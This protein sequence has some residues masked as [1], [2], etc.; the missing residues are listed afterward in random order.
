MFVKSSNNNLGIG[1]FIRM[2]ENKICEV[3]YFDLPHRQPIVEKIHAEL[4][5]VTQDLLLL[6]S[7]V[8]HHRPDG[9]WIIGKYI[10]RQNNIV[11]VK[12]G[13]RDDLYSLPIEQTYIRCNKP[14]DDPLFM[15]QHGIFETPRFYEGRLSFISEMMK[16]RAN[17]FG[18]TALLS[19]AINLVDHQ[20]NTTKKI[21]HDPIQ[22]YLLADEV[23][24]GKTI[25]AGVLI[26]QHVLDNHDF[27]PILILVPAQLKLQWIEEL[28]QRFF[29]DEFIQTKIFIIT[30]EELSIDD[31]DTEW[32][33]LVIDEAHHIANYATFPENSTER[34]IF[35]M[36]ENIA[37]KTE[38]L[39]LL[40]A[41]PALHNESAFLT[42][43]S[44]LDPVN[45][46]LGNLDAF[47]E[48]ITNMKTISLY[49]SGISL[50]SDNGSIY[51]SAKALIDVL[52]EDDIYLTEQLKQLMNNILNEDWNI[53]SRNSSILALNSYISEKFKVHHRIARTRRD[54]K[55][56]LTPGRGGLQVFQSENTDFKSVDDMFY[57][58]HQAILINFED[59]YAL[60]LFEIYFKY[61]LALS[62]KFTSIIKYRMGDVE[63]Q[64]SISLHEQE[65]LTRF[66][67]NNSESSILSQI[68]EIW[69]SNLDEIMV[70]LVSRL[71]DLCQ[72]SK[73]ILF[74]ENDDVD[75]IYQK[76]YEDRPID[77]WVL[78]HQADDIFGFDD[79]NKPDWYQFFSN[80][81]SKI[82]VCGQ[83]G[84]EGLNLQENDSVVFHFSIPLAVNRI[85][86]R[87]G[88]VDR[89]QRS[90]GKPV[91]SYII[92][93]VNSLY[94]SSWIN[95][96]D[97]SFKVFDRSIA[98]LQYL[99]ERE[100]YSILRNFT[101]DDSEKF[102]RF[103]AGFTGED[104]VIEKE[105]KEIKDFEF[106]N[107]IEMDSKLCAGSFAFDENGEE[108]FQNVNKL[109]KDS[110]KF[111]CNGQNSVKTY[112]FNPDY[113][114]LSKDLFIDGFL[115]DMQPQGNSHTITYT[116]D[117]EYA[118]SN[119]FSIAR[120][121]N[122]FF[123]GI[124]EVC[125][126][127]ARGMTYGFW[128]Q[129][130]GYPVDSLFLRIDCLL[131]ANL[132]NLKEE[133]N[134]HAIR[135]RAD[136]LLPPLWKRLYFDRQLY[137]VTDEET[138]AILN[139]PYIKNQN[140]Y[141]NHIDFNLAQKINHRESVWLNS[142][143][144]LGVYQQDWINLCED[145]RLN[146]NYVDFFKEYLNSK[147]IEAE[148][149]LEIKR[150]LTEHNAELKPDLHLEEEIYERIKNP[151]V[152]IIATGGIII[153]PNRP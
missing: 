126:K 43:L 90:T 1:K 37:V 88:R 93:P 63:E 85:E 38:K 52:G 98:S 112:I 36:V 14:I 100:K 10:T 47:K 33:M 110:Y 119:K 58:L 18:M 76:L 97:K 108:I 30:S 62:R 136:S 128:R 118:V 34:E 27:Q 26:R 44:L 101:P 147:T 92:M 116:F 21:L 7:R 138:L 140:G 123:E 69:E 11:W 145:L 125:E 137:Q 109:I 130:P 115:Q 32:D 132:D 84:E 124:N 24:L 94:L 104:G 16:Q 122:S 77:N 39:F 70:D 91:E 25:E 48:K 139:R 28:K 50:K 54:L 107:S 40:S 113:A 55:T 153:S 150:K 51:L 8:Y 151:S 149:A 78:K 73:I 121:G 67:V 141:H 49:A 129:L 142:L 143:N 81:N 103:T 86:Q 72:Q 134:Y 111:K 60:E 102:K 87:I 152:K 68:L 5:T 114:E 22:R 59:N 66:P 89:Y 144:R 75:Y 135:R 35:A 6:N 74:C 83:D 46:N 20:I 57:D 131:E 53:V 31:L 96:I 45:H 64:N 106:I 117:R 29:L 133:D 13:S 71:K 17:C 19:S 61:Y 12:F 41:T 15:L 95:F 4:I 23:G 79:F 99:I 80:A 9:S 105:I 127:D 3:E 82:L 65:V 148:S 42:M 56:T 146:I 2:D 120:I